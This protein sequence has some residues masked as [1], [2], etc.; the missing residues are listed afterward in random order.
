M[1]RQI[2][3]EGAIDFAVF[4]EGDEYIV[5]TSANFMMLVLLLL[6]LLS[7]TCIAY[8]CY[9]RKSRATHKFSKVPVIVSS[10][11]DI[12]NMRPLQ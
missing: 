6:V 4:N 5:Q 10:D 8:W 1:G 7:I 12:E 9:N 11:E 2:T 3:K